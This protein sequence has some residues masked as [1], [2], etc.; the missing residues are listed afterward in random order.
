M[1]MTSVLYPTSH[2][3]KCH[4][5]VTIRLKYYSAT[6]LFQVRV[7]KRKNRNLPP[8]HTI[9]PTNLQLL[10]THS[11]TSRLRADHETMKISSYGN[12]FMGDLN[13]LKSEDSKAHIWFRFIDEFSF[14]FSMVMIA[15]SFPLRALTIIILSDLT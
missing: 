3:P 14:G 11:I 7:T 10:L 4:I 5:T 9:P 15:F 12:L 13:F 6:G 2:S 1:T 8:S